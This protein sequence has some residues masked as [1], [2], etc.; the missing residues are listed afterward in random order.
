MYICA[1]EIPSN[2]ALAGLAMRETVQCDKGRFQ[3]ND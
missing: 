2:V 1:S 3:I